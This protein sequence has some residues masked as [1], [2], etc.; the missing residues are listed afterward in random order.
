MP[1]R[2]QTRATVIWL[3]LFGATAISWTLGA[4]DGLGVDQRIAPSVLIL[5]VAAFKVR[6]IGLYFMGLREAPLV[7]RGTFEGLCLAT[8]LLTIGMY[9]LG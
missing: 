6:L 8:G 9:L 5:V 2:V 3:V 7:L 4:I 1:S